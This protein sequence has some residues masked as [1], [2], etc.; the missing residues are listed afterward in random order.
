MSMVGA[1]MV[2]MCWRMH[3]ATMARSRVDLNQAR[4]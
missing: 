1:V 4:F 2:F 3:L